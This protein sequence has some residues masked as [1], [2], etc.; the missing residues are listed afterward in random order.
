MSNGESALNYLIDRFDNGKLYLLDEPENSMSAEFQERLANFLL[1]A[2]S[3]MH[4]Q[5]I[6]STHSPFLLSLPGAKI[7]DLDDTSGYAKVKNWWELENMQTLY[8]LF[9]MN[10][11]KFEKR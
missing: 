7:I 2:V 6:I 4:C 10:K 8:N 11:D 1:F 5:L 9:A 3:D